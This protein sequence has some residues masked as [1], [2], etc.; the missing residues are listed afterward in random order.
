MRERI[1]A[2]DLAGATAWLNVDRPPSIRD[3][4]GQLVILDFWTYCCINCMHVLP[5][6]RDLEERHREDPLVVIGVHS[7]KFDAEKD[8]EHI[9]QAMRRY[10]VSHPVAVDSEMQ[11]WSQYAVRSWPTLVIIRPDGTLA[12]VAPGEPDPSVLEAFVSEQL[13]RAREEGTLAAAPLRL[14]RAGPRDEQTLSFPG[15]VV[16]TSH[17]RIVVSDSGHHR[18][19]ILGPDGAVQDTIG[20]GL[21]GHRE[22]PF[23]EAALDDPQG[24]ALSGDS[25]YI[26]DARAHAVFRADLRERTLHRLAGTAE[27]G[28]TPLSQRTR[29]LETP[30]R[31]PWD[32]AL[33]DRELYVALAGSHQVAVVALDEGTI[34]PVAGNGREALIDGPGPQ[35]ALAQPSGLSLQNEVLYVADSES[36]G[37]RAIDL[38][39][40]RVYTLAGGPGLFDFGDRVGKIETG[41]LQHPLAVAATA[42]GLIVADTYNDKLKRFSPDG[43]RLD[44]FFEGA[45]DS[46]LSQPAGLS[47]L[48]S[49]EVLVADTNH[50]RIVK[51]SAGGER[52]YELTVRGAPAPR[53]GVAVGAKPLAPGEGGAGWFTAILPAPRDKGFAPGPGK[54]VLTVA[55]PE[56][57]ELS[58]GAPWSAALEVSRRSDL[59]QVAPEFTRGEARGGRSE[60]I[61]LRVEAQHLYDVDSEL[62]VELRAVACDAADHKACYPVKNSFRV[63]LRLLHDGGQREVRVTLPLEVGK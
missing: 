25:L 57:L 33:R 43:L 9:L 36:S 59:L 63:P 28:R 24:L 22:G 58:A 47:V 1:H 44:P 31:S 17:G 39:T 38:R 3:L 8:A 16:S 34:E 42:S 29:A 15:K 20:S 51:V 40:R 41:M 21:R 18:V 46:R 55:A 13:A 2:P 5:V 4:R 11:L 19:L 53:Y 7:A 6:L 30:L 26:A 52:A 61:E 49:G 10:G 23:A 54:L 12:A 32:L 50:H 56:G 35:A 37:V 62:L 27:L 60:E 14:V 48:P 45:V